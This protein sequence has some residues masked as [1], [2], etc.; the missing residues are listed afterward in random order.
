[1]D[2]KGF[3]FYESF[4]QA[5]KELPEE[6]QLELYRAITEYSFTGKIKWK[7]GKKLEKF[8]WISQTI[9]IL[10]K[11]QLDAN[12]AKYNN[13]KQGWR[14]EK[15]WYNSQKPNENLTESKTKPNG[16]LIYKNKKENKKEKEN[17]KKVF[18]KDLTEE[19]K[20]QIKERYNEIRKKV[21]HSK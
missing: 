13:W 19:E 15:N 2:R 12:L 9:W 3:I 6:N 10:I 16:K 18:V 21:L 17:E 4:W 14:P 8:T 5:I 11:P 20:K 1:M 7:N